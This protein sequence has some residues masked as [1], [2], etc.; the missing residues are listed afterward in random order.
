LSIDMFYHDE[1]ARPILL[2]CGAD[3]TSYYPGT[4]KKCTTVQTKKVPPRILHKKVLA[5]FFFKT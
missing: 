5:K 3:Y 2:L 4:N 1:E